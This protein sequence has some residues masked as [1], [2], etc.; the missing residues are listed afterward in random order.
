MEV[1][2]LIYVSFGLSKTEISTV[3]CVILEY[4]AFVLGSQTNRP[5]GEGED[6]EG[7]NDTQKIPIEIVEEY[8]KSHNLTDRRTEELYPRQYRRTKH[9]KLQFGNTPKMREEMDDHYDGGFGKFTS[10]V[11][12]YVETW[13]QHSS[14]GMEI[15]FEVIWLEVK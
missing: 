10:D 4:N 6:E 7:I 5:D 8:L 13:Y 15:A 11:M 12:R 9:I 2:L 14:L 3:P 1:R